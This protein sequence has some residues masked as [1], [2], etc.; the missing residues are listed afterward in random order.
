MFLTLQDEAKRI[1]KNVIDLSYFMRGAMSYESI[2]LTM[3]YAERQ[4]VADFLKE[5]LEQESKSPHP[6][7]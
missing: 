1:I 5:R 7:Y 4:L 2:L 3:S 6:V